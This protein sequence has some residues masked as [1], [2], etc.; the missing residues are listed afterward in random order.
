MKVVVIA[1]KKKERTALQGI[2]DE[3]RSANEMMLRGGS[4]ANEQRRALWEMLNGMYPKDKGINR[5]FDYENFEMSYFVPS[6]KQEKYKMLKE[7][8][9][10]D[11]DFEKA[12]EYRDLEKKEQEKGK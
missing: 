2:V 12:S 4:I 1:L 11:R 7:K 10:K 3:I 8:A 9:V 6:T 5:T